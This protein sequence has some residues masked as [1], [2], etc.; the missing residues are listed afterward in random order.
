MLLLLY[1]PT[2]VG[3]STVIELLVDRYGFQCITTYTTRDE[4]TD[5]RFKRP[6]TLEE[7]NRLNAAGDFFRVK[8][9]IGDVFYA[10]SGDEL[11]RSRLTSENWCLDMSLQNWETYADFKPLKIFLLPSVAHQLED[12]LVMAGRPERIERAKSELAEIKKFIEATPA[13]QAWSVLMN[14]PGQA[15]SVAAECARLGVIYDATQ[16]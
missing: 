3:K 16:F 4:R 15:E 11:E 5:D 13:T 7:F 8:P 9:P 6:V 14:P 2:G 12:Q 1:G 10:E